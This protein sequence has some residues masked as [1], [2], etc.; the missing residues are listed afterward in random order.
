MMIAMPI[1]GRLYNRLQPT[2]M[3]GIGI[4]VF[5]IG[6]V[7]FSHITLDTSAMDM[8]LPLSLTGIGF[9]FLFVTLA[10][11]AL[12]TIPREKLADAAGLNSFIR[13][14][15][16]SAGLAISAT[17]LT[18]FSIEAQAGL[19]PSVT[20]GR[21]EISSFLEMVHSGLISH[22]VATSSTQASALAALQGR[23]AI[24]SMV[25]AF[26]KSFLLQGIAFLAALP[27]LFFLRARRNE[28]QKGDPNPILETE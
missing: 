12:S 3:V 8:L 6:S 21:P 23:V 24:Q 16:G 13:Q 5:A 9:S 1:A 22:G 17:L 25:L 7:G 19:I 4:V 18:R 28:V 11:A 27:L 2:V 15:G 26:E 10:T 20:A 14:L